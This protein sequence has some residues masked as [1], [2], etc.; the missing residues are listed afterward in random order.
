MMPDLRQ[1]AADLLAQFGEQQVLAFF[2][3]LA[4]LSPLFVLAPLFSSRMVP[5]RVRGI[6]AVALAVG[7]SPIV[8]HGRTLPV[9]VL[10]IGELLLKEILVGSAF[11]FVL[12]ALFAAVTVAGT[13]LDYMIGFSFGGMIDPVNGT[14]STVLS[15]TYGLVALLIF[16]AIGGDGWTIEGLTRTYDIV[17]LTDM[18]SL[19]Y[20]VAGTG[21]AFVKIFAAAV[22]IAGPVMLALVLTDAA[23]GVISRVM[24]Q[25]NVFQVGF[26]AKVV[27]GL[28]LVGA[29][30]P[31]VAGW[32]SDELQNDVGLALQTLRVG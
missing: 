2:L 1:G 12:A 18:P 5:A 32:L 10:S 31:F 3:V 26:P 20:M 7:L 6:V 9:D 16:I 28:L 13:F 23:F 27:L 19:G 25:L 29:T 15:R 21:E 8:L 11:A 24:P 4:R 30:L 14:Q 22:Q 17:G